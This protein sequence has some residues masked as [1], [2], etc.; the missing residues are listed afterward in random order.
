MKRVVHI[1]TRLNVG[2]PAIQLMA[3]AEVLA[4]DVEQIV[5]TGTPAPGESDI[6]ELGDFAMETISID[7][8]SRSIV[9]TDLA[10]V[11][12]IRS[13]LNQLQPDVVHTHTSKAGLVGRL[14]A[15]TLPRRPPTVHTFH[16]TMAQQ[17][18]GQTRTAVLGI[19]RLLARRTNRLVCLSEAAVGHHL[20]NGIG[21]RDQ[22]VTI[23]PLLPSGRLTPFDRAGQRQA[24]GID[25]TI[26]LV[27]YVGRLDEVKRFD[28]FVEAVEVARACGPVLTV[29]VAGGGPGR[30]QAEAA[31]RRLESAG[32]ATLDFGWMA[33]PS[34]LLAAADVV[35][36]SSD[37]EGLPLVL[38]EAGIQRTAVVATDVGSI[39]D[40]VVDDQTGRLCARS[41]PALGQAVGDLLNDPA[42][43]QRLAL[44]LNRVVAE[45]AD[46]RVLRPRLQGLYNDLV[47]GP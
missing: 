10:V 31:L 2:G 15:W 41:A 22:Y 40:Y 12:R 11:A 38:L 20:G 6:R 26:N 25:P 23:G 24:L 34:R 46:H 18:Q 8:L 7:G 37:S 17:Y 32:I 28:R 33:E 1:I 35:V 14:A 21:A 9:P 39:G 43:R 3:Q 13:V 42:T 5:V 16:A 44:A 29:A 27:A 45:Q 30:P 47:D 36:I 19:E 4:D